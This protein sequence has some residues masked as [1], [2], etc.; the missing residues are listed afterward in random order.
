[1][2]AMHQVQKKLYNQSGETIAETLIAMLIAS[3]ALV[4]LA[5]MINSTVNVVNKSKAKM[6]EYYEANALLE[7]SAASGDTFTIT[8]QGKEDSD[9]K[10]EQQQTVHGQ[11]KETL[12]RTVAAY[13][14]VK[15]N[16]TSGGGTG[17]N[18]DPGQNGGG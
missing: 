13:S 14:Y 16:G 7:N 2:K 12:S 15:E 9:S 1:M 3:I 10:L 5:S 17:G 11:K 8:I 6:E 18:P 4:M